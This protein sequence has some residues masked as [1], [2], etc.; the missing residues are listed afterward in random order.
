MIID[1]QQ[2]QDPVLEVSNVFFSFNFIDWALQEINVKIYEKQFIGIIGPNGGGKTTFL[3][4]LLGILQPHKGSIEL[5]GKTPKFNRGLIGYFPQIKK[6]DP[7]YPII[8]EDIIK[9]AGY[10]KK[11]FNFG[12]KEKNRRVDEV[13]KTLDIYDYRHRRITELSGGQRNRVFLARALACQPKMLILDEPM[14]GLD[15]NLQRAFMNTLQK[16]NQNMTIVIV[17]HNIKLLEEYVDGFICLNRC[18][19]HGMTLHNN[20][21][22]SDHLHTESCLLVKQEEHQHDQ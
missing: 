19:A 1:K 2:L 5:Y 9:T 6:I 20:V 15:V 8:V 22:H 3:K 13:M 4:L 12:S 21:K 10:T 7:D 11:L 14:A 18:V 17:D 16:M